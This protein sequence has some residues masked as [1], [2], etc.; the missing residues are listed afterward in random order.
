MEQ[1]IAE[2]KNWLRAIE[3]ARK[4]EESDDESSEEEENVRPQRKRRKTHGTNLSGRR[5]KRK[6][7]CGPPFIVQLMKETDIFGIKR[8]GRNQKK[9]TEKK[10]PIIPGDQKMF[11]GLGASPKTKEK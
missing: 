7:K 6:Y 1:V 2:S 4:R 5:Q 11:L 9:N 8:R 3:S 10:H